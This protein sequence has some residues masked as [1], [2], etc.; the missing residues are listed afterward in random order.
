MWNPKYDTDE[1]IH[2]TETDSQIENRPMATRGKWVAEGQ[3]RSLGQADTN[4]RI[5]TDE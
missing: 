3:I 5:Q 1:L 4:H 2:E